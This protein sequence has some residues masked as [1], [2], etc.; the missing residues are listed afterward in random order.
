MEGL[1]VSG[2]RAHVTL[3]AATGVHLRTRGYGGPE[4]RTLRFWGSRRLEEGERIRYGMPLSGPVPSLTFSWEDT[5]GQAGA[6]T[7]KD[8][9]LPYPL[10]SMDGELCDVRVTS[11]G[12]SPGVVEGVLES[13]CVTAVEERVE[14]PVTAGH[15]DETVDAV[16]LAEVTT[17]TGTIAAVIGGEAVSVPFVR[18]GETAFRLE[19]DDGEERAVHRVALEADLRA[20]LEVPMP[21]LV[22]LTRRAAWTEERTQTVTVRR[23]GRSRTVTRTVT[24]THEDGTE[25]EHEIS[26]RLSI[27]SSYVDVDVTLTVAHPE[28]VLAKVAERP[29]GAGS[30]DEVV[31]GVASIAA[32]E[33]FAVLVLPEPEE[34]PEP[35][36]QTRVDDEEVRAL[37]GRLDGW[38]WPS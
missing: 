12:W 25:T 4:G 13:A 26:A 16:L 7:L 1:E 35:A 17:V 23:P 6:F 14:L 2:D 8:G 27:P 22:E 20:A 36:R 38:A 5:I 9:Q 18:D 33:P 3:R 29:P 15:R 31:E 34:E 30:R 11:L 28:R 32:D 10:P 37:F 24:V 21:P 19:V